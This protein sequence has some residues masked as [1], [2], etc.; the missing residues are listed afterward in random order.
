V[1]PPLDPQTAEEAA[2][3]RQLTTAFG[4]TNFQCFTQHDV[5][6]LNRELCDK[7]DERMNGTPLEGTISRLFKGR[8]KSFI[9]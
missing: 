9:R 7:L 2:G 6:E 8:Y 5:Q 3:T 4:W 1:Q